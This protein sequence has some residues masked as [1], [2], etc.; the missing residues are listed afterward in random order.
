MLCYAAH[1]VHQS[2]GLDKRTFTCCQGPHVNAQVWPSKL[3]GSHL[4]VWVIGIGHFLPSS[5]RHH[6][7]LLVSRQKPVG[8]GVHPVGVQAGH[9]M[10][11]LTELGHS[12]KK[13]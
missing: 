4:E 7:A 5:R 9:S 1:Y 11:V 10:E 2:S 6:I 8:Y 13:P 12:Q 3:S